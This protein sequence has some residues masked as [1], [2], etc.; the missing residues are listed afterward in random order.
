MISQKAL[1][2]KF[3]DK[4][5]LKQNEFANLMAK[6]LFF[7]KKYR[8]AVLIFFAGLVIAG[9]S[10][11][12][13]NWRRLKQIDAFNARFYQAQ[14][15]LKKEEHLK[16][17]MEEFARLPASHASRLELV[18]VLADHN[19]PQE[20]LSTL[21]EGIESSESGIFATLMILKYLDLLKSQNQFKEAAVFGHD[22]LK[23]VIPSFQQ[24]FKLLLAEFH[25]QAD[26][27]DKAQKIYEELSANSIEAAGEGNVLQMFDPRATD[28]AK[29]RLLLMQLEV[30]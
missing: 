7:L 2:K 10:V 21:K 16:L 28:K 11:P 17:V 6:I 18:N 20:A 5:F 23:K 15:S 12:V 27:K 24:D 13:L 26:E 30:L 25:L 3:H 9:I 4:D 19:K 1:E 14:K 29:E 8:F 22:H